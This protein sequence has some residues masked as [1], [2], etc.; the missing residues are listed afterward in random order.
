M[1]NTR[2]NVRV[3]IDELAR[4]GKT[5]GQPLLY[6]VTA[7]PTDRTCFVARHA[8]KKK[9][10]WQCELAD[11]GICWLE[12]ACGGWLWSNTF[13]WNGLFKFDLRLRGNRAIPCSMTTHFECD[14][15]MPFLV[16]N[17]HCF[18]KYRAIQY[19]GLDLNCTLLDTSLAPNSWCMPINSVL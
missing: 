12:V 9:Y 10:A 7:K 4:R 16:S 3:Y 15:S 11:S 17:T 18:R 8:G 2:S 5:M 19:K 6:T 1:I 13:F 14:L